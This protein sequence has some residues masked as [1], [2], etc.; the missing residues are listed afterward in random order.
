[1][2]RLRPQ[3][4]IDLDNRNTAMTEQLMYLVQAD[5]ILHQS[6]GKSVAEGMEVEVLVCQF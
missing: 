3:V 2:Q 5:P 1:M 6:G 4:G